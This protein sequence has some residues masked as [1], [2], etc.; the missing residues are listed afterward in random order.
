MERP[1]RRK[2]KD[3]PYKLSYGNNNETYMI[4]F[5]DNNIEKIVEISKEIFDTFDSF[6]LEDISQLHK[7]DKYIDDR[8][9]G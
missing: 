2:D 4:T 3:N 6:E 5:I 7:I 1:K 8:G 9:I